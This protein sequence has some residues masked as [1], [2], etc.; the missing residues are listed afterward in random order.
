LLSDAARR[1]HGFHEEMNKR[2]EKYANNPRFK[3]TLS[4]SYKRISPEPPEPI[5]PDD[6]EKLERMRKASKS[7]GDLDKVKAARLA[8]AD[9]YYILDPDSTAAML[10][11]SKVYAAKLR[12]SGAYKQR[13]AMLRD[14][15]NAGA[16]RKLEQDA[17]KA[18]ARLR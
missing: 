10:N 11:Y 18:K 5:S 12:K 13:L 6:M 7:M 17:E 3:K 4:G 8:N 2:D 16:E 14:R 1:D 9:F 15:M